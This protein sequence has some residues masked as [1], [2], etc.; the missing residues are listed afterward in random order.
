VTPGTSGIRRILVAL[1]ASA[2][3]AAALEAAVA[4][5]ARLE[6]ELTGLFV[7][8]IEVVHAAGLPFAREIRVFQHTPHSLDAAELEAQ[9][10]ARARAI[11]RTLARSA[12][13]A[14]V[15]FR[16]R[17]VRGRVDAE[18]LAA[19]GEVDL[20]VLGRA[21]HSPLARR[22]LGSTARAMLARGSRPVLLLG[23]RTRLREP[24]F[25]VFDGS[26]AGAR[27]LAV[28][29]DLARSGKEPLHVIVAADDDER[30]R[31]L[32]RTAR[33]ALGPQAQGAVVDRLVGADGARLPE[34]AWEAGA[35]VLVVPAAG[36]AVADETLLDA[37]DAAGCPLLLVR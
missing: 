15:P 27:A 23:R 21:G 18:V 3:S 30:A 25:A 32:E 37:L 4:L 12:A 35:G 8:D 9:L 14:D 11:E 34:M 31:D 29:T 33:R 1:D 13:E 19:T 16:F 7:E 26:Q 10:R 24:V 6:A 17:R 2:D 28:A 5:A 22:R 20:V 36:P